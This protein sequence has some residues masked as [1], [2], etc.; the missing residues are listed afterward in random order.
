MVF[1]PDL[2]LAFSLRYK[3]CQNDFNLY[4]VHFALADK[5]MGSAILWWSSLSVRVVSLCLLCTSAGKQCQ[6]RNEMADCSHLKLTQ[7]PF[8][9]P[10]NITG[11]DISHNQLRQLGPANLTKYSQ[12]VYLNV[13]YNTIS[14]LQPEL[15]QNVPLLQILKLEHNELHKLPD[16]VFASCTNLTELYLGYNTIYIKNDP[17]KTLEVSFTNPPFKVTKV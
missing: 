2:L 6:I 13:G 9:L 10:N 12:L 11:L 4:S 7:I 16:R 1:E 17:F 15:C 14:K 8:D 5:T 3:S